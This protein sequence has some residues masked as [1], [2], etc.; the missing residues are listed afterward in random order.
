MTDEN[1]KE[2]LLAAGFKSKKEFGDLMGLHPNTTIQ[3]GKANPYPT[4]LKYTL[5]WAIKAKK[6]DDLLR[7]LSKLKLD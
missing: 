7:D 6:Y 3:W 4:W 1:F 2:L 5:E